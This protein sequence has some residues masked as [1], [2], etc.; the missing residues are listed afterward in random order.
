VSRLTG[1]RPEITA[2]VLARLPERLPSSAPV[3]LLAAAGAVTAAVLTWA[4]AID[5][6]MPSVEA[7][8]PST[9]GSLPGAGPPAA[10]APPASDWY[11]ERPP[12]VFPCTVPVRVVL[13]PGR[14]GTLLEDDLRVTV[15][16]VAHASGRPI[17][18][19]GLE[20]PAPAGSPPAQTVVVTVVPDNT[21]FAGTGHESAL[22]VGGD[23]YRAGVIHDG[24]VQ[25]AEDTMPARGDVAGGLRPLL[26]HELMHALGVGT[27]SSSTN[28]LMYPSLSPGQRLV[29]GAGDLRALAAV[30][31]PQHP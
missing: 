29:F 23:S 4:G 7:F 17:V 25:I 15:S 10:T 31:C 26:A 18:Y 6:T 20:D 22:A 11:T 1:H 2:D 30:G 19:A 27:H 3:A 5:S 14:G 16:A 12:A 28:D 21:A 9:D 8:P 24:Y 13:D